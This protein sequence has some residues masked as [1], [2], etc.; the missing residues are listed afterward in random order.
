MKLSIVICSY[1]REKYILDAMESVKRQNLDYSQFEL[2]VVNNNSTD[3]T[4]ELCRKFET[5]KGDLQYT[6]VIEKKAGLS[7]ARNCGIAH[8]KGEII[9][10]I[11]DDAIAEPDFAQNIIAHFDQYQHIDAIGGKVLPIFPGDQEPEWLSPY[12]NGL[13]TKV[14]FGDSVKPYSNKYPAG[15]N[16]SFRKQVFDEL[17]G[18]NPNLVWRNDDKYIFL[19]LYKNNKKT[20]YAPNVVVHHNVDAYRLEKEFLDKLIGFIGSSERIRLKGQIIELM[21][22][23]LEYIFKLGAAFIIAIKYFIKGENKKATYLIYVRWKVL[24]SFFQ[25]SVMY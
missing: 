9:T 6:Y 12:L 16:M 15:C 8:A 3:S 23:P 7:N 5:K 10:F 19:K 22:K 14:D 1:N 17:G 25:K 2:L 13:V 4:H 20:L 11:D 21:K 24:V 18:F